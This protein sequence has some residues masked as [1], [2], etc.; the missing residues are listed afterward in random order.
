M[1]PGSHAAADG[2][3]SKDGLKHGPLEEKELG[4]L[5]Y[6]GDNGGEAPIASRANSSAEDDGYLLELLMTA[7]DA[8]F[9]VLDAKSL[10]EVARLKLP[11]RV[12][13]GVHACWLDRRKPGVMAGRNNR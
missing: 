7:E 5:S 11:S 4:Y 1:T 6:G 2:Y 10:K 8:Q 12:P 9:L 3:M 13:F